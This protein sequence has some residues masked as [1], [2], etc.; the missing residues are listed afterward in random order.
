M[1]HLFGEI[2]RFPYM[3][4]A[5]YF[6]TFLTYAYSG[7]GSNVISSLRDAIIAAEAVFG[8]VF[9]NV[10]SVARKFKTVHEV[11][12]AATDENCIFRCPDEPGYFESDFYILS[13]NHCLNLILFICFQIEYHLKTN[14][15]FPHQMDAV[16]LVYK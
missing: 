2:M 4:I 11:F 6:L 5:I 15:M 8:D 14:S 12:D 16:H 10:I 1:F 3:K 9:K 13:I 7:Y